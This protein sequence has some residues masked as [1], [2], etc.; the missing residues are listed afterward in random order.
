MF[1]NNGVDAATQRQVLPAKLVDTLTSARVIDGG[2]GKATQS[3]SGYALGWRRL[4]YRGHD[5]VHHS[6]SANGFSSL[7]MFAPYDHVGLVILNNG[8]QQAEANT[9]DP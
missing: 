1:L 2:V 3:I 9:Q 5:I 7:I 4:S 8:D 6:G